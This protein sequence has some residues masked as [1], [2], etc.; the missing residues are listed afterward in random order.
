M[1][2][3]HFTII[4]LVMTF[5]IAIASWSPIATSAQSYKDSVSDSL[6]DVIEQISPAVVGIIG[7]PKIDGESNPTADRFQLAH[8]TGVIVKSNGTIVTN[9]HVVK[10][11]ENIVV[12]TSDGR[13]FMGQTTHMDEESDLALVKINAL[14]LP[15]ATLAKEAVVRPGETVIAIGTPVSFSLRNSVS[16]GVI[17]GVDRSVNAKYRLL[18]TDA[19]INPGNSGGPLVNAR[20]EVIGINSL[21]FVDYAVDNL[22]FAIPSDTVH[23]VMDHFERFG[24]VKRAYVGME[25]EESWAALVGFPNDDALT[26][27][28]VEE[29]SAA[30]KLDM[31]TGD[32]LI[33]IDGHKVHTLLELN[34]L[35]KAYIPG[36]KVKLSMVRDQQPY[37][38]NMVLEEDLYT[39]TDKIERP[40]DQGISIWMKLGAKQM[41]VNGHIHT[42][43]A[44]KS[45]DGHTLVPLRAISEAFGAQVKWDAASKQVSIEQADTRIVLTLGS[46]QA[47]LNEAEVQLSAKPIMQHG[48]VLVPLRFIA[49]SLGGLV[50]FYNSTQEIII[51]DATSDVHGNSGLKADAN[52]KWIGDSYQDWSM[53]YPSGMSKGYQSLD[54]S[55]VSFFDS[56]GE[57]Y[58]SVD[59]YDDLAEM[60]DDDLVSWLKDELYDNVLDSGYVA[61]AEAPYA[62]VLGKYDTYYTEYRA[63]QS[64]GK[65]YQLSLEVEEDIYKNAAKWKIY[66]DLLN[67]FKPSFDLAKGAV[68]DI[69]EVV[70]GYIKYENKDYGI[71]FELPAGWNKTYFDDLSFRDKDREMNLQARMTSTVDGDTLQAW[72]ERQR[73]HL[74]NTYA[75][76]YLDISETQ[77][78]SIADAEASWYYYKTKQ[79]D[80]WK[81]HYVLYVWQ[82]DYKYDFNFTFT[83]QITA[84]EASD[85]FEHLADTL[86]VDST[87]I[88]DGFG[89]LEDKQ[90]FYDDAKPRTFKSSEYGYEVQ[91]PAFWNESEYGDGLFLNYSFAGGSFD[92]NVSE[93][94]T[95][96]LFLK[97]LDKSIEEMKEYGLEINEKKNEAITFLG[98][99][100]WYIEYETK[101]SADSQ[102][103]W[104]RIYLVEKDDNMYLI[105]QSL[106]ESND[107]A[108]NRQLLQEALD[109]FTF[110]E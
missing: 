20:G 44:P 14:Q 58:L 47:S 50:K 45:V 8:G 94:L 101:M 83:D 63:Y 60:T 98:L 78:A 6:P 33:S 9:A 53:K 66:L 65:V 85:I 34:E 89:Q 77:S 21:K 26:V 99:D 61:D 4:P 74:S 80:S 29:G 55:S 106:S 105:S 90:D 7:K 104:E 84:D 86:Q 54:A 38:V 75:P 57:Y 42:I 56:K 22:G 12:V 59:I 72:M 48:S 49:E 82:G 43:A 32:Q 109:S 97:S 87:S 88:A 62:R 35:L 95:L 10:D 69:T 108:Y 67:S 1:K 92:V 5:L 52:K 107:T 68:K 3:K 11:L 103:E 51:T 37:T 93:E 91:T 24:Y 36:D 17:S 30:E 18:Q 19:A 28:Y 81:T 40:E 39:K 27:S 96:D 25:L 41:M 79:D 110:T 71:A 16:V 46:Q 102:M 73:K 23:Y 13:Q 2:Q 100:A 76:A 64:N 31:Q 70:N 15:T